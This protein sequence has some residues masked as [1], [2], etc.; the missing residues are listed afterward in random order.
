MLRNPLEWGG[1]WIQRNRSNKGKTKTMLNQQTKE[2]SPALELFAVIR[3]G[4]AF[5]AIATAARLQIA[6]HLKD[7]NFLNPSEN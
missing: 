3:A 4:W 5:E 7:P 2:I 6:D 1:F